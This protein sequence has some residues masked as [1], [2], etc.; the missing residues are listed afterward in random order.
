MAITGTIQGIGSVSG[1]IQGTGGIMAAI[2]LPEV[3]DTPAY[4][5]PYEFTPSAAAQVI[6]IGGLRATSNITINPVPSNYGLVTW[7][8]AYLT[9]S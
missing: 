3:V 2:S 7:N 6:T 8:G 9:I 1:S 5:G 4:D